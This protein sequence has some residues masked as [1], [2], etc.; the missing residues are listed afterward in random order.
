[1]FENTYFFVLRLITVFLQLL[2]RRAL[3]FTSDFDTGAYL[4]LF[5]LHLTVVF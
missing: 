3:F 5:P 1:M 4:W 2:A